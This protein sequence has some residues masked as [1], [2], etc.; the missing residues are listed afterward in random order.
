MPWG[1]PYKKEG[2]MKSIIVGAGKVGFSLASN[3]CKEGYD[4]T[5]I[6]SNRRRLDIMEDHLNINTILGNAVRIETLQEAGVSQCDLIIAVTDKDE[7]NMMTCFMAKRSGAKSTIAR[8]R[9][10][11]YSDFDNAERLDSLGID[12]LINPEKVTATEIKKLVEFPEASYVG[13]FGEGQVLMMEIFLDASCHCLNKTLKELDFP[14]PCL[15]VAVERDGQLL[16]PRGGDCLKAG[17]EVLVMASHKDMRQLEEFLNIRTSKSRDIVIMSGGLSGYYLAEMLED[18]YSRYNVKVL[19]SNMERC[20]EMAA[21]LKRTVVINSQD[22][23]VSLFEDENVGEADIFVAATGD[24]K[25]NLFSCVMAKRMGA[26]KTIAQIRGS[27]YTQYVLKVGVD[28]VVSPSRLTADAILRFINR[29]RVLSLTRFENGQGQITEYRVPAGA[30][31]VGK[32]LM[33]LKFPK[34]ALICLLV[35]GSDCIIPSGRD[36]IESGDVALVFS[37][38]EA[39]DQVERLLTGK[40]MGA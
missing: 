3:F 10:P 1:F 4:V 6:D 28:N 34:G 2:I 9:T 14:V 16:I 39:L 5:V 26:K 27:D 22:S 30:R 17:D 13:F 35:R 21:N 40:E 7:L 12:M 25:D 31:A 8:V 32:S 19:D 15:I 11:G 37:L 29:T 38:P 24:D 18:S 23:S 33:Q 20:E 36:I